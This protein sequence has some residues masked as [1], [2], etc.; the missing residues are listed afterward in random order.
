MY[1]SKVD[2]DALLKQIEGMQIKLETLGSA[3]LETLAQL[4]A[5]QFQKEEL[6]LK[7]QQ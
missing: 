2:V 3:Q 1:Y 4:E 6:G 7:L 5:E